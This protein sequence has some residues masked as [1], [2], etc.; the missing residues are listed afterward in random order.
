MYT[1]NYK[2]NKKIS[3]GKSL[4][5]KKYALYY[6]CIVFLTDNCSM[7]NKRYSYYKI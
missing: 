2:K 6:L 5:R 3:R 7:H 4:F 1:K